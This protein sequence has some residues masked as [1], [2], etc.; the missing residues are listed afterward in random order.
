MRVVLTV[1]SFCSFAGFNAVTLAN[2]HL[3]DFGAEGA[4][5]TAEVLKETG[6][7]YFGIS[8]GDYLSS[9]VHRK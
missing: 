1:C 3:N 7:P 4:N 5:F 8:F 2:N 6:I 9:Q